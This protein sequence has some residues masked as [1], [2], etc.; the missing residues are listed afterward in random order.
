MMKALL[1]NYATAVSC[2]ECPGT[3]SALF[4]VAH[5]VDGAK[6]EPRVYGA[7]PGC[8]E[9]KMGFHARRCNKDYTNP[10]PGFHRQAFILYPFRQTAIIYGHLVFQTKH[11]K[12]K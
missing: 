7:S 8:V 6:L 10:L 4:Q 1:L 5:Q 12:C 9:K 11:C 2:H 3:E